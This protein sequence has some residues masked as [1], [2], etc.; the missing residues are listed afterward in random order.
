MIEDKTVSIL[1]S[2]V[3]SLAALNWALVSFA[4]Y[5]VLIDLLS[6]TEGTTNYKLAVGAIGAAAVAKTYDTVL[7]ASEGA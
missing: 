3:V 5:N 2:L 1:L 7:W 6:L 4:D